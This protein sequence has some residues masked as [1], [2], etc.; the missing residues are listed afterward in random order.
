MIYFAS[1]AVQAQDRRLSAPVGA[2]VAPW[3]D[4]VVGLDG[5]IRPAQFRSTKFVTVREAELCG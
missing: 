1:S 5:T 2:G 4:G 3:A